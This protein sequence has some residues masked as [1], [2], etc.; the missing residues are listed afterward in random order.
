V[1]TSTGAATLIGGTGDN[2]ITPSIAF[3]PLGV[4][5][6]LKGSS[7]QTNTLI[8]ID[9]ATGIGTTIGSMGTSG[10]L[11]ITMRTDSLTTGVEENET[12]TFPSS[13]ALHQNYPNPFNPTTEIRYDVPVATHVRLA[14]FDVIGREVATLVDEVEQPG[15]RSVQ[16]ASGRF[17]SGVYFYRLTAGTFVATRKMIVMK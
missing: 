11:A 17:A 6:G 12:P 9:T 1:N 2:A 16:F 13:F 15:Y 10:L 3:N 4:L 7:T 5:Y 8:R 14:V